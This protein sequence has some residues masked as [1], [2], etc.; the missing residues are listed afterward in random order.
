M[1]IFMELFRRI[2]GPIAIV[3]VVRCP[4][5]AT[6]PPVFTC[7]IMTAKRVSGRLVTYQLLLFGVESRETDRK[8]QML[9]TVKQ[10]HPIGILIEEEFRFTRYYGSGPTF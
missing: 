6:H 5:P 10:C 8:G 2:M 1:G 4:N 7:Q 9:P 3:M